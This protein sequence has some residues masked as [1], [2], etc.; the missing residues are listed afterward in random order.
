MAVTYGATT[1]QKA[2]G[3]YSSVSH[4]VATG[5]DRLLVVILHY[6]LPGGGTAPTI[7]WNGTAMT[8]QGAIGSALSGRC[9]I[10][11]LA[12]PDTGSHSLTFSGGTSPEMYIVGVFC[13]YG[14][15]SV[16]SAQTWTEMTGYPVPQSAASHVMPSPAY[17]G[18]S[19]ICGVSYYDASAAVVVTMHNEPTVPWNTSQ[20][21]GVPDRWL[22]GAAQ[23]LPAAGDTTFWFDND[24]TNPA[25]AISIALAPSSPL[26]TPVLFA[27][28]TYVGNGSGTYQSHSVGFTPKLVIVKGDQ[29]SSGKGIA[30]VK[31]DTMSQAANVS[32]GTNTTGLD[33]ETNGFK[34]KQ[35]ND[36]N[37]RANENGVTYYWE[38]WGGENI[39]TGTYQIDTTGFPAPRE[40]TVGFR[41][42]LLWLINY[43]INNTARVCFKHG[44]MGTTLAGG[45]Q[46]VGLANQY[47]SEL[48]KELLSDGFITG[49]HAV[50]NTNAQNIH[51]V[52]VEC[53]V[54]NLH[55]GWY[56]GDGNDNRNIP[57]AVSSADITSLPFNP[58]AVSIKS[59]GNIGQTGFFK[60]SSLAGDAAL[61]YV[62]GTNEANKIQALGTGV[63]QVGTGA[64]VN[65]SAGEPIY[66]YYASYE[67]QGLIVP[68][69][70]SSTATVNGPKINLRI[71][72]N[73]VAATSTVNGPVFSYT[74]K[75]RLSTK[76]G[77]A[78][79]STASTPQASLGKY[80]STTDLVNAAFENLFSNIIAEQVIVGR[81]VY[82]CIFLLNS[83]PVITA[84]NVKIWIASQVAGGGTIAL[85]LDPAGVVPKGQASAQAA[86]VA[87]ETTAPAGVTFSNPTTEG[88]ALTV[89]TLD[90]NECAAI[91]VRLTIPVEV[92]ATDLDGA[93][94]SVGITERELLWSVAATPTRV[95]VILPGTPGVVRY[96]FRYQER[97]H[98][99]NFIRDLSS[100][101]LMGS[102]SLDNARPILRTARFTIDPDALPVPI[103][104]LKVHVGV[105][106]DL[107]VDQAVVTFQLGLF[108]LGLP[109]ETNTPRGRVWH[110]DAS[111]LSIHLAESSTETPY[112]VTAG[113][114]LL[115]AVKTILDTFDVRYSLPVTTLTAPV[116]VTWDAGISW[117]KVINDLLQAGNMLPIYA[118]PIGRLTTREWYSAAEKTPDVSYTG[119][120]MILIPFDVEQDE[121]VANKIIAIAEDPNRAELYSAKTNSDPSNPVST[122]SLGRVITKVIKPSG[123]IA[124]QATLDA[125]AQ[126]ALEDAA[127][128]HKRATLITS[129]DPRRNAFEVYQLSIPEMAVDG[130]WQV[131]N[132]SMEL[133][134][135]GKMKHELSHGERIIAT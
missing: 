87:N 134:T 34:V 40:V 27:Q 63:F 2:V 114:N 47:S 70:I 131:K 133:K 48:I 65:T 11:T 78:G 60:V 29:L 72:P 28:G 120:D 57:P 24:Q 32:N 56:E 66:Y 68:N 100:G 62:D 23:I 91:W 17:A 104:P 125:I 54:T 112:T 30:L 4:T 90:S 5:N 79:D 107:L 84:S 94:L 1:T 64:E 38:A 19:V 46:S 101:F 45:A 105:F 122:V 123:P 128:I 130:K 129:L 8:S 67:V 132:W 113:T 109:K 102:I 58:N 110:V 95:N 26:T 49:T 126:R 89:G 96:S 9:S 124:N 111:D 37:G 31:S 82:K 22:T 10:Y 73:T 43:D 97:D 12:N 44:A 14:V 86:E 20:A 52:A 92:P 83:D 118:E 53:P 21:N 93:I 36:V 119:D 69:T 80:I 76:S 127:A 33:I 7:S 81:T 25:A 117:L 41:P 15:G 108:H 61:P 99:N 50:V 35:L 13:A 3:G 103:E 116:D 77:S 59:G 42:A 88:T 16:R 85:G 75:F 18:D 6:A 55:V 71:Y 74:L 115:T 135:G 121:M 39:S 51:W 106:M 98:D